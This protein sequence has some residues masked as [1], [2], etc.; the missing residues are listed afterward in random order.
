VIITR[1]VNVH[2][3]LEGYGVRVRPYHESRSPR[4]ANVIYGGRVVRRLIHK[5]ADR[6]GL[7]VRCIQASNP[8]CFE[9]VTLY[10]VWNL[11]GAHFPADRAGS[12]IS[13]FGRIDLAEIKKRAA[14]LCTGEGGRLA[15]TAQT[16]SILLAQE[17]IDKDDAA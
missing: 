6:C 16:M 1:G 11:I 12:A 2:R 3:F 10:S 7:T 4:P 17:I 14:R 5:D 13:A 9:D 8:T 15:K